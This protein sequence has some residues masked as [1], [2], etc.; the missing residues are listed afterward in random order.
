MALFEETERLMLHQFLKSP[1]LNGLVK[2]LVKPFEEA[3]EHLKR[4]HNWQYVHEAKGY[5]L[6][7]IGDIVDFPRQGLSDAEYRRWLQVAIL[8]N[9]SKGTAE[10][11]F[12]ILQVLFGE[13]PKIQI[14]EYEP[15]VVTFTF[16]QYPDVPIKILLSI[17]RRA[18]PIS[19]KCQFVDA[20]SA[21]ATASIP[22]DAM[23]IR[24]DS[25]RDLP[26]F[27]LDLTGFDESV[28]ADFFEESE[29]E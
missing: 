22:T 8:L 17:I 10:D 21:A 7:V 27:Q 12:N 24:E 16:F 4:L 5:T 19:T 29:N 1:K 18:V 14:D 13:R 25:K 11:V 28:F 26:T 15:N 20:S 9:N 3:L 6:D 2:E 23:V